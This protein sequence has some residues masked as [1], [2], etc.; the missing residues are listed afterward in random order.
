MKGKAETIRL[1]KRKSTKQKPEGRKK[2]E[3]KK[4]KHLK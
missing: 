4:N 2:S 1:V 3:F